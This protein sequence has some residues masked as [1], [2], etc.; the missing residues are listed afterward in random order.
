MAEEVVL[1][2]GDGTAGWLRVGL[3]AGRS[4]RDGER[5]L[6]R[7]LAEHGA[8][9]ARLVC[10]A[11]DL[12]A[13]R[14]TLVESREKERSRLRQ[15]LHDDLGPMLAGLA[16]QL[17]TLPELVATDAD[18]A[19]ERLVRLESEA[20]SALE[21][22]R[23]ISRDLRPPALDELGLVAAVVEAGRALGVQVDV[24]G[25]PSTACPR[26]WRWRRT[27]S[28]P[29]RSSTRT[30]TAVRMRSTWP[31]PCGVASST[32]RSSTPGP[33]SATLRQAWA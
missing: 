28:P 25:G 21:R 14:H 26:R 15:D 6:L 20:R 10:L 13:A 9:A 3:S 33:V 12:A 4:L 23:H 22:T 27:A 18:L 5:E 19:T 8:R 31:W 29:R 17:G 32:W 7:D 30:V 24:R 2:G 11:E 16:M 1:D